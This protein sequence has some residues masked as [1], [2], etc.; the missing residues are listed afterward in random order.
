MT[1]LGQ[2][3]VGTLFGAQTGVPSITSITAGNTGNTS[4]TRARFCQIDPICVFP[5]LG[6]VFPALGTHAAVAEPGFVKLL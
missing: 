3:W 4:I 5:A 1:H 6:S 2:L